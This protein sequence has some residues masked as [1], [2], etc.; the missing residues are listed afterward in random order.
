M[1]DGSASNVASFECALQSASDDLRVEG[2]IDL[3]TQNGPG[4]EIDDDGQIEPS[5]A[6]GDVGAG[7]ERRQTARSAARRQAKPSN[8]AHEVCSW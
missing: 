2:V 8:V 7:A 5:L 4:K 1:K 6:G 3:P